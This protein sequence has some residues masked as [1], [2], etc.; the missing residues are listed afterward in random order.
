VSLRSSINYAVS[1]SGK[2]GGITEEGVRLEDLKAY[3]QQVV[4]LTNHD[5]VGEHRAPEGEG[6]VGHAPTTDVAFG[7]PSAQP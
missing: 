2:E 4:Y 1:Y 3:I 7:Q 5:R 6:V